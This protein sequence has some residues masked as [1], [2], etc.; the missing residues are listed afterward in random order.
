MGLPQRLSLMV[1][2]FG[3]SISSFLIGCRAESNNWRCSRKLPDDRADAGNRINFILYSELVP[4]M[5]RGGPTSGSTIN[6]FQ[7][8]AV[9]FGDLCSGPYAGIFKVMRLRSLKSSTSEAGKKVSQ[10]GD[11]LHSNEVYIG[12]T[13]R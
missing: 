9:G 5:E 3:F 11:L 10:S 4:T 2:N 1:E 8:P 7:L 13:P 6:L 12:N